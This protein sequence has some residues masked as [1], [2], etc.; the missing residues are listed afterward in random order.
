MA[1]SETCGAA[2]FMPPQ[3]VSHE[4]ELEHASIVRAAYLADGSQVTACK[5][6]RQPQPVDTAG[7]SLHWGRNDQ[8]LEV[9]ACWH[10]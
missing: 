2:H 3:I 7:L 4:I 10:R 6:G 5:L 8:G 1:R 9:V